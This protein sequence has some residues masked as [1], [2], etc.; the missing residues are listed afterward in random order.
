VKT[1][2]ISDEAMAVLTERPWKGNI[3]ELEHTMER[4]VALTPDGEEISAQTCSA[5]PSNGARPVCVTI[6]DDGLDI[7]SYLDTVEKEL[8][9][10]AM[11]KAGGSQT[12]AAELLKMEVH[13]MRY[14]LKKYIH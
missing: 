11:R 3:R 1:I 4:A 6:P 10:E 5:A 13:Q 8:V 12:R 7:R 2:G 14:L 9:L